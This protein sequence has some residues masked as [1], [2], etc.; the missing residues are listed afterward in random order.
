MR[1]INI[2]IEVLTAPFNLLFRTNA[3]NNPNKTVKP[4]IVL[5]LS[6]VLVAALVLY[7]YRGVIFR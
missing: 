2:I 7:Y 1:I 6:L 5:L 3:V 4:W